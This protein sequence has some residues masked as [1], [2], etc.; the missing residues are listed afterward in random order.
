M[1]IQLTITA[2]S[3][4]NSSTTSATVTRP[5]SGTDGFN[6]KPSYTFLDGYTITNADLSVY[7]KSAYLLTSGDAY[8]RMNGTQ[9]HKDKLLPRWGSTY[10]FDV[11]PQVNSRGDFTNVTVQFKS[12]LISYSVEMSDLKITYVGIPY[13]F[14]TQVSGLGSVKTEHSTQSQTAIKLTATPEIGYKFKQWSNGSTAN[15]YVFDPG[16]T[17]S[18]QT[19]TAF[20]EPIEYTVHFHDY[21]NGG[22][23]TSMTCK[24]G[25]TYSY[26]QLPAFNSIPDKEIAALGW[27]EFY[28]DDTYAYGI[29]HST[30]EIYTKTGTKQNQY[31]PRTTFSNLT[32]TD[33]DVLNYY[34][35]S[36]ITLYEIN[37]ISYTKKSLE[38][39]NKTTEYRFYGEKDYT[40][41]NLPTANSGY[42]LT[43]QMTEENSIIDPNIINNWF[44]SSENMKPNDP[45]ITF[46]DQWYVGDIEVYSYETPI[47]YF[48][49][50]YDYINNL[51]NPYTTIVCDYG[52][53]Y[54]YPELPEII[55]ELPYEELISSGWTRFYNEGDFKY[56]IRYNTTDIYSGTNGTTLES[57]YNATD[58]FSNL[59]NQDGGETAFYF[60]SFPIW[61]PVQ[62]TKYTKGNK[63][64]YTTTTQYRLQ[65]AGDFTLMNLP[66]VSSKYYKL[67]NQM[68]ELNGAV[69]TERVNTW[70]I[71]SDNIN[72]GDSTIT[73]ISSN[74]SGV[75]N[76][77][78]YETPID[79]KI[80]YHIC[81]DNN[82]EIN[83]IS[84]NH[85]YSEVFITQQKPQDKTQYKL[86]G[87]YDTI[88]E[89]DDWF[90][91]SRDE[92]FNGIDI[93]Y[94]YN[95]TFSFPSSLVDQDEI[96]LYSY[97]IPYAY[98]IAYKWL[99][100][101]A[102]KVEL[103][104]ESRYVYGKDPI[105]VPLIPTSDEYKIENAGTVQWYY[106]DEN[107][108]ITNN[109]NEITDTIN[110]IFY[111]RKDSYK[112][113]ITFS[114]NNDDWGI[115]TIENPQPDNLYDEGYEIK[116]KVEPTEIAY[117]SHWQ[118][119]INAHERTIIVGSEHMHYTVY[120]RSNQIYIGMLG[121]LNAYKGNQQ[122]QTFN[123][124]K[125]LGGID[126]TYYVYKVQGTPYGFYKN[127]KG[128]YESNNRG[129]S[130]CAAVSRIVFNITTPCHLYLDCINS[131]YKSSVYYGNGLLS[132]INE[133]APLAYNNN[134]PYK[135]LFSTRNDSIQTIDYGE[136]TEGTFFIDVKYYKYYSTSYGNDSLQFKI[137]MEPIE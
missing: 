9:L 91:D 72:P 51:D 22:I 25:T 76:L 2:P 71:S 44:I 109:R 121:I 81:N 120:F 58:T 101:F 129:K 86:F 60:D 24:Y 55:N 30:Q 17:T 47:Q 74:F 56:G 35:D 128:Y 125:K 111:G 43:N 123:L 21:I 40:L 57:Y 11:L 65:G 6:T 8:V 122:V 105:Q 104:E 93:S 29:H 134:S 108:L 131:A 106:Y 87:W 75:Y 94:A 4:T 78:S 95:T 84:E 64:N 5:L 70:F 99:D 89:I 114:I 41:K 107:N 96:H 66:S 88:Q 13:N 68:T 33:R 90:V 49:K 26:P 103:P 37:Y 130:Y 54:N 46:I 67:T 137:R 112:R 63:N 73:T 14:S 19:L 97:Y 27:T 42:K 117:L 61:F 39:F 62:Y 92:A 119:G 36:F 50:F 18:S 124:P 23:A 16:N 82:E 132:N 80:I 133:I 53:K 79:F 15:P 52:E 110:Y 83:S 38:T 136:V 59:V 45:I 116:V 12:D 34:F 102:D 20:F 10:T 85:Y 48:V 69:D 7:L 98:F 127:D 31:K 28:N 3:Y 118:D 32:S 115:I 77:Y 100:I 135:H 113:Q 1:S 126:N